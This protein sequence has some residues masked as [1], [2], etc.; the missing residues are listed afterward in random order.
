MDDVPIWKTPPEEFGGYGPAMLEA[1]ASFLGGCC[2][3]A[4]EFIQALRD[5][6]RG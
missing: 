4:P 2:G 3:T 1:G 5:A 6:I